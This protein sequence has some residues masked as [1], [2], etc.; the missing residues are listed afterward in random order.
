MFLVVEKLMGE[1]EVYRTESE[2]RKR[3]N[4]L[5]A[6]FNV[7]LIEISHYEANDVLD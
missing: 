7:S 3:L 2:S 5:N 1:I 4:R 6:I